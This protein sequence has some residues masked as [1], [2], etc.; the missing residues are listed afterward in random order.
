MQVYGKLY[1]KTIIMRKCKTSQCLSNLDRIFYPF[2]RIRKARITK[3]NT[4]V[5]YTFTAGLTLKVNKGKER[6]SGIQTTSKI[7][8]HT[9]GYY[10]DVNIFSNQRLYPMIM[11]LMKVI[12]ER[13]K[14]IKQM[15]ILSLLVLGQ[16]CPWEKQILKQCIPS[17]G[18]VGG[19]VRRVYI[20]IKQ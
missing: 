20:S 13:E 7:H 4:I 9:H 19:S 10:K 5:S 12:I 18:K 16:C 17:T 6:M 3:I 15:F 11:V 8:T 1:F 14:K 2:I